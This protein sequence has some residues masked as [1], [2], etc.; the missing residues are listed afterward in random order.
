MATRCTWSQLMTWS[1][2]SSNTIQVRP[3]VQ[4]TPFGWNRRLFWQRSTFPWHQR[5][6]HEG[7]VWQCQGHANSCQLQHCNNWTQ[8]SR[9][10]QGLFGG[11]LL[12]PQVWELGL[13]GV[14]KGA[15]KRRSVPEHE[16]GLK[17]K[18]QGPTKTA[19]IWDSNED[20]RE[21]LSPSVGEDEFGE[22][23]QRMNRKL[24]KNK[25]QI[26]KQKQK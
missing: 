5:A 14:V 12:G 7:W 25:K 13:C 24:K 20:K 6:T 4:Q 23:G 8:T 3:R 11:Q 21:R 2:W 9:H 19:P 17:E 10:V 22:H 16:V 26:K 18:L 1:G 15:N